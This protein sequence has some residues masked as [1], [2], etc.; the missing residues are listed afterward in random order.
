M[1]NSVSSVLPEFFLRKSNRTRIYYGPDQKNRTE[2]ILKNIGTNRTEIE[3]FGS[4]FRFWFG[5][6][7]PSERIQN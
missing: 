4:I 6:A 7:H 2:Q 5:F 1:S 3:R